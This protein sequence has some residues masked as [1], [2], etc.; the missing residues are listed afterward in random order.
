VRWHEWNSVSPLALVVDA[1][2]H[3][4]AASTVQAPNFS[5]AASGGA[6]KPS[7]ARHHGTVDVMA[8]GPDFQEIAHCGGKIFV[9][10]TT[11]PDGKRRVQFGVENSRPVPA[12]WFGVYAL[13]HYGIPVRIVELGG[14]GQP[15][16]PTPYE[17]SVPVFIGSDS[18]QLFGHECPKCKGYWRSEVPAPALCPYCGVRAEG[19]EFLTP[20]Q[21][22]FAKAV[23]DLVVTALQAELDGKHVIDM[24][25]VADEVTKTGGRPPFYYTEESQQK[26]YTCTACGST[27]DILGRYGFCSSCGTRNDLQELI[28]EI[29]RINERTRERLGAEEALNPAV[30]DAVSAFDSM[31]R[32]YAGHLAN[33]VPMKAS[34]REALKKPFHNVRSKAE[35]LKAWFGI[36][37]FAGLRADEIA[38]IRQMFLRR[39]VHE[40]N[41]GEVDQ[42]YLDESADQ[43]VRLKQVLR[44]SSETIFRMTGLI[45]KM[46]RNLHEGFHELFPPVDEPIRQ[47]KDHHS[48]LEAFRREH[49]PRV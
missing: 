43:S 34:R 29:E 21:R 18:E 28:G 23:C 22:R 37:L 19:H 24:D 39:H 27:E 40:H 15:W 30:P 17:P 2:T 4:S 35:D 33:A 42:R 48:A 25:S 16:N 8:Y 14:I 31:A 38:F 6:A 20:G 36:D 13:L 3:P 1:W 47:H 11:D 9:N 10:A 41:G 26:H 7:N 32:Q 45:Q 44:E 5:A 46:A 49:S 12:A